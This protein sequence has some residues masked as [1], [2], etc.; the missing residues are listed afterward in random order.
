M[1]KR[2]LSDSKIAQYPCPL[3]KKNLGFTPN[4]IIYHPKKQN[5][6]VK[7]QGNFSLTSR[8]KGPNMSDI[9]KEKKEFYFSIQFQQNLAKTCAHNKFRL[10]CYIKINLSSRKLETWIVGG[11][12]SGQFSLPIESD[13]V[14]NGKLI[15][16]NQYAIQHNLHFQK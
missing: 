5:P 14:L 11:P 9:H 7:H 3:V 16:S 1:V 10:T 15:V 13:I 12:A 6:S 4:S 2:K 8:K